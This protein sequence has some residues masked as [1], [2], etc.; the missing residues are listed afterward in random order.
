MCARITLG[1]VHLAPTS[2]LSDQLVLDINQ[3]VNIRALTGE[4]GSGPG[5]QNMVTVRIESA[6]LATRD[7]LRKWVGQE[8]LYRDDSGLLMYGSFPNLESSHQ[9]G[10]G[11][12]SLSFT[13][14]DN[15]RTAEV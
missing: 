3:S 7:K 15:G 8:L 4:R 2:D 12:C 6:T 1:T 13:L 14:V 5:R 11:R 9:P 10:L